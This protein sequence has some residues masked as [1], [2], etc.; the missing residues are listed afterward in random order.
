[1]NFKYFLNYSNN[2]KKYKFII[3]TSFSIIVIKLKIST[4]YSNN[5]IMK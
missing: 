5:Y 1:M 2:F 3:I 4:F